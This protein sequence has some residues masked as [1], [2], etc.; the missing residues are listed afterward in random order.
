M[1]QHGTSGKAAGGLLAAAAAAL[2]V[3]ASLGAGY[4]VA[5]ATLA[6]GSAYVAKGTALAHVNG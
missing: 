3:T 6:D 5:H 4:T 1:S 2:G